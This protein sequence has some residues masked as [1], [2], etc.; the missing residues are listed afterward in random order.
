MEINIRANSDY[1]RFWNTCLER[2]TRECTYATGDILRGTTL[3]CGGP[4][5]SQDLDPSPLSAYISR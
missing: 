4:T 3:L 5:S 1:K 2:P